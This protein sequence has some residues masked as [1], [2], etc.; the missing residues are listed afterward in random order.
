MQGIGTPQLCL[1]ITITDLPY[2]E[3]NPFFDIGLLTFSSSI[4]KVIARAYSVPRSRGSAIRTDLEDEP[5]PESS[6]A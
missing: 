3:G 2:S 1:P 4:F 6:T 5:R